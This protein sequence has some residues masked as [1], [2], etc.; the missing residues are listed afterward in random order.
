MSLTDLEPFFDVVPVSPAGWPVFCTLAAPNRAA[1]E[2][3]PN[4]P[5][6]GLPAAGRAA[7][8]RGLDWETAKLS[9]LG[10]AVEIASLCRWGDEATVTARAGDLQGEVWTAAALGGFA[11]PQLSAR[12]AWNAHMAGTDRVVQRD[13]DAE[14]EWVAARDLEGGSVWVPVDCV[15]LG[16]GLAD[17]NGCAAGQSDRDARSRALFELIE[18]D[19]TGRW[20]YGRR[21]RP[22]LADAQLD[23]AGRALCERFTNQGFTLRLFDIT[24]DLGV[25][26][27]AAAGMLP[28]GAPALGF[29]SGADFASA[30]TRALTEM[31]QMALV[32]RGAGAAVLRADGARWLEEV[33][34]ATPPISLG[35]AGV[36]PPA[37]ADRIGSTL[38]DAGIRVAFVNQSR[39]ELGVPVW[40]ALSPDLCHWKPRLGRSRLLAPD[41]R[42]LGGPPGAMNPVLL[43]L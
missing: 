32:L 30:A 17:T 34:F 10:E 28:G 36:V 2:R 12:D 7:G 22:L 39:A 9:G 16:A 29:A 19:A 20:W 35:V 13:N 37:P 15:F 8:G 41:P 14:M 21:S 31:G 42:D 27:V 1:L 43:R 33:S 18:R 4:W 6:A 5:R 3:L 23:D 24:T 11:E 40:R 25:A 26:S 38:R